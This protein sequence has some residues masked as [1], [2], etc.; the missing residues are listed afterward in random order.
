MRDTKLKI[1]SGSSNRALAEEICQSIG[2]PLGDATVNTYT[3]K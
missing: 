1:F 2:V 3:I